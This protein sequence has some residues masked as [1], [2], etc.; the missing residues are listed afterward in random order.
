MHTS[1]GLKPR[2]M[3]RVMAHIEDN[4][5]ENLNLGTL[6]SIACVSK[7]HFVRMFRRSTGHSPMAFVL[8][9][10]IELAQ[11]ALE[12]REMTLASVAA[13]LGF[14]DQS[15]FTRCFRRHTGFTPGKYQPL[16]CR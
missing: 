16:T 15:H 7:F 11:L 13:E 3:E 14:Y 8:R 6:A 5:G 9:R 12:G 10:R 2:A 1:G 4:I